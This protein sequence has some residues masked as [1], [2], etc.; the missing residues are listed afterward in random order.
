M[1]GQHFGLVLHA[2]SESAPQSLGNSRVDVLATAAQQALVGRVLDQRMLEHVGRIRESA[3]PKKDLCFGK[4]RQRAFQ[5]E[6]LDW[7]DRFQQCVRKLAPDCRTDLTGLLD[8]LEPVE[9]RHQRI[10][11]GR[12]NRERRERA[13]ERVMSFL[14]DQETRFQHHFGQFL[15]EQRDAV[16]LGDYLLVH[17]VRKAKSLGDI[18][19]QRAASLSTEAVEIDRGAMRDLAP[20]CLE[21]GTMGHDHQPPQVGD[22]LGDQIHQF[23]RRW[24][25]PVRI[26]DDK[27]N[28]FFGSKPLEHCDKC[29]QCSLFLF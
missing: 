2:D 8:A 5:L 20:M 16:C 26:L 29:L 17:F 22:A 28:R 13:G 27:Q 4:A 21:F 12:R 18:G 9:A 11:Q 14:T 19:D 3:S 24:V 10:V 7:S 6:S 1:Q 23:A 15:D 25:D